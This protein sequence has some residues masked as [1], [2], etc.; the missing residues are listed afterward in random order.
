MKRFIFIVLLLLL[1]VAVYGSVEK[2]E[3]TRAQ[4]AL[5][6]T[7]QRQ[8]GSAPSVPQTSLFVPYWTVTA[9]SQLP[10]LYDTL[11]YFGLV[12]NTHGV[13]TQE[14][15][16]RRLSHFTESAPQ[17]KKKLLVIRMID[18]EINSEVLSKGGLQRTIV[19]D[20]IR[21]AK[22]HG[23]DGV[24]LDLE[25]ASLSFETVVNRISS[26]VQL[27][28][29]EVKR[30]A[31]EFGVT[32]YGDVFYRARPFNVKR[33][34]EVSDEVFIMAYDFHKSR[35][36][37]GP[38]FQ[39][40]GKDKYGYDFQKM[41]T[42]Y[43]EVVPREKLTVIFGMFG[44]DWTIDENGTSIKNGAP[45]STNVIQQKFVK[46]CSGTSCFVHEDVISEETKITYIDS[47]QNSHEIWFEDEESVEKKK[48]YLQSLGI[49]STSFW[50]HSYF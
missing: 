48:E 2:R 29:K 33:I 30:E 7:P 45:L 32:L 8:N 12:V 9:K 16:Y 3:N 22:E 38:N 43:L 36:N 50:A 19:S 39:L 24:V 17:G 27:F 25:T 11:L 1:S 14:E 49:F 37:P 10:S 13:N 28:S 47:E 42:D 23:F 34:G 20:S 46:S 18:S 26:F 4:G 15:G 6:P 35:G 31:L 40:S 21:I 5:S 44:Y 41:I